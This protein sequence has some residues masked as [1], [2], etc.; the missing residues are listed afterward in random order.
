MR[1]PTVAVAPVSAITSGSS[2]D[3]L[4]RM[5]AAASRMSAL[6][7]STDQAAQ[8]GWASLAAAAAAR[9]SSALALGPG[10]PSPRWRG[11]RSRRSRRTRRPTCP[12][13]G[14]GARRAGWSR[15]CLLPARA[16]PADLTPRHI[17]PR[18]GVG[19]PKPQPVTV[20]EP[21]E[22]AAHRRLGPSRGYR[23]RSGLQSGRLS[24]SNPPIYDF[25]HFARSWP[26]GILY[27]GN[28]SSG[29]ER[30]RS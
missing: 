10:P 22:T 20:T 13:S 15:P 14:A 11:S 25:C 29:D 9:A 17:Q 2:S 12:R 19:P 6:R 18:P 27:I 1:E 16:P 28:T 26:C 21:P 24:A 4:A 23:S 8:P 3:D 5:A 7:S 30:S